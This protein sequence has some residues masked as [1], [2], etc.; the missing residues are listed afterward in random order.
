[1]DSFSGFLDGHAMLDPKLCFHVKD[2]NVVLVFVKPLLVLWVCD[3]YLFQIMR[4]F[5]LDLDQNILWEID[6]KAVIV[7][8]NHGGND[9][10]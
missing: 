8:V 1:M 2:W 4:K 3:I 7:S 9:Q 6:S 10:F 5:L